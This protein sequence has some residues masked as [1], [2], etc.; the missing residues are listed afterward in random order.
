MFRH[1]SSSFTL[2]K[3]IHKFSRPLDIPFW[4]K[5]NK[6]Y[7]EKRKRKTINEFSGH[8]VC[9]AARLQRHTASALTSLGPKSFYAAINNGSEQENLCLQPLTMDVDGIIYVCSDSCRQDNP[10]SL[11]ILVHSHKQWLPM[12]LSLFTAIDDGCGQDKSC[13]QPSMMAAY[14]VILFHSHKQWLQME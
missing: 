1:F 7:K 11:V 12:K 14:R 9:H 10:G 3:C 5:S 4:E 13:S 8:Y 6:T 2:I